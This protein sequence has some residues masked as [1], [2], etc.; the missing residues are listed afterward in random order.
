MARSAIVRGLAGPLVPAPT[1]PH[2]SD[3]LLIETLEHYIGG[4]LVEGTSGRFADAYNPALGTLKSRVPLASTEEVGR[5]VAAAQ[6]AFPKWAGATPLRRARVLHK[7]KDLVEENID[8]LARIIT[9]E[10]GKVLSDAKGE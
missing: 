2:G 6:A 7:F 10:H 1:L 3:P 9:G 8:E 4:R 5:A